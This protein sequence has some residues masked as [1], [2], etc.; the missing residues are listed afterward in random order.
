MITVIEPNTYIETEIILININAVWPV[1]IKLWNCHKVIIK[2]S[3]IMNVK[4][5]RYKFKYL[6][7]NYY[8]CDSLA[9]LSFPHKHNKFI[10][11]KYF[12][13]ILKWGILNTANLTICWV[14]YRKMQKKEM[15][16]Y[17]YDYIALFY[18]LSLFQVL[19]S[20]VLRK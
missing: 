11:K 1:L 15:G 9:W 7:F 18:C 16:S 13:I 6:F 10:E 8:S 12:V 4:E 17:Q 19:L 20:T 14:N 2:I 5:C 3:S